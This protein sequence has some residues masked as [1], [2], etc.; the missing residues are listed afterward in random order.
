MSADHASSIAASLRKYGYVGSSGVAE[1]RRW[2]RSQGPHIDTVVVALAKTAGRASRPNQ[3]GF[4]RALL[5]AYGGRCAI[6]GCDVA[7][8]LE[9]AHIADWRSEN[10]PGAGIL[11]RADLHR[12]LERG[13]LVID[14]DYTVRAAPSCYHAIEG[15]RLRLPINRLLWPRLARKVG[16]STATERTQ[17]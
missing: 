17:W 10:D 8:V 9:A 7:E 5:E 14:S 12:L 3:R 2:L 11:L 6:T 15:Q 13:L 16:G 1:V 4:R